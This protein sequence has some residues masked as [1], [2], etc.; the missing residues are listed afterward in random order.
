MEL[1]IEIWHIVLV[2][3]ILIPL[4]SYVD[5]IQ[6]GVY[7]FQ[8]YFS[9]CSWEAGILWIGIVIGI[10]IQTHHIQKTEQG[11]GE[12]SPKNAPCSQTNEDRI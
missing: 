10:I 4:A 3:L 6:T 9:I 8:Q 2:T 12:V 5:F 1:K 7:P 11:V